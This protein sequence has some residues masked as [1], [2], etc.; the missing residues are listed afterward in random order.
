VASWREFAEAEPA[1]AARVKE[2]FAIRKHK[3][4]ATLRRDGSPRISGVEMEFDATDVY[5]GMMPGS[6][7]LRDLQRDPRIALHS[8]TEDPPEGNAAGWPGEAKIAGRAIEVGTPSSADD[9]L[10]FRLDITEVVFTHLNDAGDR[11][12]VESWREGRGRRTIE[13]S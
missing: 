2:R 9:G 3:T 10:R 1:L 12:A 11:L 4:M 5:V 13:R 8:P 6:A 7:K